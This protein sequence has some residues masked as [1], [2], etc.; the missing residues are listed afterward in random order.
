MI[1]TKN[2]GPGFALQMD[3]MEALKLIENLTQLLIRAGHYQMQACSSIGSAVIHEQDGRHYP[4]KI[5]LLV[6]PIKS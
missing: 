2:L 5:D 4:S 1:I 3:Q 6:D